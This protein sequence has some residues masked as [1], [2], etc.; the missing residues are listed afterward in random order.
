M[1]L[2]LKRLWCVCSI[3]FLLTGCWD[4]SEILSLGFVDG[5]AVEYRKKKNMRLI[6]QVAQP[7]SDKTSA[8]YLNISQ[9]GPTI[10]EVL[11][12][13]N[14]YSDKVLNFTHIHTILMNEEL[15]KSKDF[16]KILDAFLKNNEFNRTAYM[17]FTQS[18]PEKILEDRNSDISTPAV[19]ISTLLQQAH[20]SLNHPDII[21]LGEFSKRML[22]Q[23]SFLIP[24]IDIT[25]RKNTL[26][27]SAVISGKKQQLIGWLT[28]TET[29]M[30]TLLKGAKYKS[31]LPLYINYHGLP[32]IYQVDNVN[33]NVSSRLHHN[34]LFFYLDLKLQGKLVENWTTYQQ[35][36]LKFINSLEKKINNHVKNKVQSIIFKMQKELQADIVEFSNVAKIQQYPIWLKHK[37]NWDH[38]FTQVTIKVEVNS[39]IKK[40]SVQDQ[41]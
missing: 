26:N 37:R 36:D 7:S 25:N 4:S 38:Y 5:V 34:Q 31:G 28:P 30:V 12:R 24:R 39:K 2:K 16:T 33:A 3:C 41:Q 14:S 9:I 40:L 10:V 15:G 11:H 29:R 22:N 21:T 20:D 27:G 18:S 35:F 17:V 1:S 13:T 8:K 6:L 23:S 19:S 32:I